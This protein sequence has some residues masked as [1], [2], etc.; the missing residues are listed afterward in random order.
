MTDWESKWVSR[1]VYDPAAPPPGRDSATPAKGTPGPRGRAVAPLVLTEDSRMK[2]ESR[3]M[4]SLEADAAL[5]KAVSQHLG[6]KGAHAMGVYKGIGR[7]VMAKWSQDEMDQFA[8]GYKEFSDDLAELRAAVLPNRSQVIGGVTLRWGRSACL[9]GGPLGGGLPSLCGCFGTRGRRGRCC[10]ALGR[11][12]GQAD[13]QLPVVAL[14]AD[15]VEFYWVVWLPG[16]HPHVRKL[17]GIKKNELRKNVEVGGG[18]QQPQSV[19]RGRQQ[20]SPCEATSRRPRFAP[21]VDDDSDVSEDE[22]AA[23][24]AE[25]AAG[26]G[27]GGEPAMEG[28]AAPVQVTGGEEGDRRQTEDSRGGEEAKGGGGEA[29]ADG[30]IGGETEGGVSTPEEA[31]EAVTGVA[32]AATAEGTEARVEGESKEA[33]DAVAG[34]SALHADGAAFARGG[35][36]GEGRALPA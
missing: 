23:A 15:V 35:D 5:S 11:G 24:E 19:A 34:E 12:S 9:L 2:I 29:G 36:D 1:C 30:K 21:Q 32:A 18:H 31:A 25:V 8:L 7:S 6:S 27:Q 33:A 10:G 17:R 26:G 13:C 28:E 22:E 16:L 14:Q 4:A 3:V 20:L